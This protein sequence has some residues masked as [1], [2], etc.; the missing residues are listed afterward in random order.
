MVV[1]STNLV[2][3]FTNHLLFYYSS[4][5]TSEDPHEFIVKLQ[6]YLLDELE[7]SKDNPGR[8]L[9]GE[10]YVEDLFLTMKA[11]WDQFTGEITHET[12]CTSTSCKRT[13]EDQES[14]TF[15]LLKFPELD[16]NEDCTVDSLIKHY[17]PKEQCLEPR[18]CIC[19]D[20]RIPGIRNSTITNFPSFVCILLCRKIDDKKDT[21]PSAVEFPAFDFDING[22]GM[23]YDLSATVH[24]KETKDGNGHYT[25]ISRSQDLQS[26]RWFMYDDERVS[27]LNFTNMNNTVKRGYMKTAA[28]LFYVSQSIIETRIKNANTIDLME[29]GKDE[30]AQNVPNSEMNCCDEDG[31]E[32]HADGSSKDVPIQPESEGAEQMVDLIAEQMVDMC[33][34]GKEGKADDSSDGDDKMDGEEVEEE[35]GAAAHVDQARGILPQIYIPPVDPHEKRDTEQHVLPRRLPTRPAITRTQQREDYALLRQIESEQLRAKQRAQQCANDVL[36]PSVPN[37]E[38]GAKGSSS[39]SSD[40]SSSGSSSD[41]SDSSSSGS[42]SD[43]SDS[44]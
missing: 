4:P 25:A 21:I 12:T 2:V 3:L 8:T 34:N 30:Q 32:G 10:K 16:H 37:S 39:D 13:F 14:F 26:Q 11:F 42:S 41:S 33:E 22:N 36:D 23:R 5:K 40:S 7:N 6:Q 9:H 35:S 20:K 27:I 17:L 19:S 43:S 18:D 24:Y 31:K 15:L 44:S 1:L 28:I 38:E 29:G